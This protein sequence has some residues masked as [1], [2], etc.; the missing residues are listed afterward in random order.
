MIGSWRHPEW[1]SVGR[2]RQECSKY[3]FDRKAA[4]RIVN[5]IERYSKHFEGPLAGQPV[6]LSRY[7]KRILRRAVG[8]KYKETGYRVVRELLIFIPRKNGKSAFTSF[9]AN[10]F[11]FGDTE[12]APTIVCSAGSDEQAR[13]VFKG[14]R[15][16][17]EADPLLSQLAKDH[18]FK[19]SICYPRKLGELKVVSSKADT[20]HGGNLSLVIIDEL[21]VQPNSDLVDVLHT[22]TSAR[23]Q[24][25]TIYLT[26]AGT[27]T[28]SVCYEIY[29]YGKAVL[30]REIID[31]A[32]FPVIYEA[33]ETDNINDPA[34]WAKVNP[35]LGVSKF[36]DYIDRELKKTQSRPHYLP[37]VKRLEFN[38]WTGKYASWMPSHIWER[39]RTEYSADD[40]KGEM[41]F[42]GM[43]LSSNRDLTSVVVVVPKETGEFEERLNG[44]GRLEKHKI[45]EYYLF[46]YFWLPSQ[47]L[48]PEFTERDQRLLNRLKRYS[49][50]GYITLMESPSIDVDEIVTFVANSLGTHFKI[51]EII[52]D[53]WNALQAMNQLSKL[54]FTTVEWGQGFGKMSSPTKFLESHILNGRIKHN[55]NPVLTWN[56]ENTVVEEDAYGNKRP[57][58]K[59]STEKIDGIVATITAFGRIEQWEQK[60]SVYK[61]RGLVLL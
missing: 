53:K 10:Y 2:L 25:L 36:P 61:S 39:S 60:A 30:K 17:V 55:G 23:P 59:K 22:S 44:K 49:E 13:Q 16:N 26:T 40:F 14:C 46:P 4:R 51:E 58:K 19:D 9:V 18:I 27:E 50:L 42:V 29:A 48:D 3:Y 32:F 35:N 28:T 54:R 20:K 43:D 41:A 24:P 31:H 56:L 11:L 57:N 15:N 45:I 47:S 6:K 37:T 12:P 38:Q 52:G 21:H 5:W 7:Q 33:E 1:L 34:I 8:W